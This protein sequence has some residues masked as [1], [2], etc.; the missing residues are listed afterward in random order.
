MAEFNLPRKIAE[1][2]DFEKLKGK[3]YSIKL[4]VGAAALWSETAAMQTLDNLLMQ[5]MISAADYIERV[6]EGWIKDRQG[7]L[8]SARAVQPAVA[9]QVAAARGPAGNPDHKGKIQPY[10]GQSEMQQGINGNTTVKITRPTHRAKEYTHGRRT[11][12]LQDP[13]DDSDDFDDVD[14]SA[15]ISIPTTPTITRN[16]RTSRRTSR[17]PTSRRT[18]QRTTSRNQKTRKMNRRMNQ[19]QTRRLS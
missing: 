12:D 11:Y 5:Q 1:Q 17:M 14:L 9:G 7:L 16:R 18:N 3:Y 13:A 8:N 15:L 19:R 6:P 4:D 10:N 2:Y